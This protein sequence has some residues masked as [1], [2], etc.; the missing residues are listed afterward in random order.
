M[1]C[2]FVSWLYINRKVQKMKIVQVPFKDYYHEESPKSQIYLHHTAGTG[3]GITF[4]NGGAATN[5]GL[6]LAL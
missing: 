5:H 1:G 6:P 3:I 2:Y 4:I